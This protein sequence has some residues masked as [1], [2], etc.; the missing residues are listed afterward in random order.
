MIE[1]DT[2][3]LHTHWEVRAT[4]CL[5]AQR[6]L[7]PANCKERGLHSDPVSAQ[8]LVVS[9]GEPGDGRVSKAVRRFACNGP[10]KC[11]NARITQ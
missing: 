7:G 10:W 1:G 9:A 5:W 3:G 6:V 2:A 8:G 4:R 11:K